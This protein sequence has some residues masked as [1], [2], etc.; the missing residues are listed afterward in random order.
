[1]LRESL[2]KIINQG[3]KNCIYNKYKSTEEEQHI[4]QHFQK[5]QGEK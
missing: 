1:M 3:G 5:H 4:I 2:D